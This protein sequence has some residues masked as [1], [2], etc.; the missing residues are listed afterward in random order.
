VHATLVRCVGNAGWRTWAIVIIGRKVQIKA[1][2]LDHETRRGGGG[3]LDS[4]LA[5]RGRLSYMYEQARR[6]GING[7]WGSMSND[8]LFC[9]GEMNESI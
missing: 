7:F 8:K 5:T 2:D 3:L 6:G 4:R 9:K 1:V